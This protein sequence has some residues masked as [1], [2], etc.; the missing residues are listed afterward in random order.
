MDPQEDEHPHLLHG[1]R[2]FFGSIVSPQTMLHTQADD[3]IQDETDDRRHHDPDDEEDD[4]NAG[5][6]YSH[7][8]PQSRST[9]HSSLMLKALST[10][11]H[12]TVGHRPARRF[13]SRPARAE[14]AKLVHHVP[15]C[16]LDAVASKFLRPSGRKTLWCSE[17]PLSHP[18]S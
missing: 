2:S 16:R 13:A 17:G 5:S 14:G 1:R 7:N 10:A 12:W 11:S 15:Q 3:Q 18:P 9:S 4:E 8:Y 6:I